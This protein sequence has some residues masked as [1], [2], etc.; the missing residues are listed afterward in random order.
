M[1]VIRKEL[2]ETRYTD[3]KDKFK[4]LGIPEVF[5]PGIKKVDLVDSAVELLEK[6]ETL[7]QDV[8]VAEV[9]IEVEKDKVIKNEVKEDKQSHEVSKVVANKEHWTKESIDKRIT[10]LNNSFIQH[11]GTEKGVDALRRRD[12]LASASKIMF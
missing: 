6:K 10:I 7:K 11:R 9:I 3:L 2:E 4:E 12:I 8:S 5:K 1:S